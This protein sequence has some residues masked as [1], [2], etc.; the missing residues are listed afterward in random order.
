APTILQREHL[1]ASRQSVGRRSRLLVSASLGVT[2]L[3]VGL[4]VF[5]L[6]S[7]GRAIHQQVVTS[8]QA[9]AVESLND[10]S[11]DPE[12]SV[13]LALRAVE[14]EATPQTMLA[15]R[16]AL[17]AS[18]LLASLPN[19]SAALC[20]GQAPSVAF[21]PGHEAIAEYTCSDGV[22]IADAKT[23]RILR[24]LS[25]QTQAL[26]VL[27]YNPSGSLLAVGTFHGID[28]LSAESGTIENQLVMPGQAL[29]SQVPSSVTFNPSGKMIG[30]TAGA[31][32]SAL[33]DVPNGSLLELA[34]SYAINDTSL[35][36]T[37]DSQFAVAGTSLGVTPVFGTRTGNLVRT[38][39]TGGSLGLPSFVAASPIGSLLA[40]A[41]NTASG[42]G[43]VEIWNSRTWKEE[44]VLTSGPDDQFSGLAFSPDGTRV[45]LAED[46][47]SATVWSIEARS[48]IVALL[49]QTAVID[50][51]VF[52]P[53]GREVATASEDG[54]ARIWRA[55]GPD[56]NDLYLP[57]SIKSVALF[58]NHLV[59]ASLDDRAVQVS[60]W[61]LSGQE[62]GHFLIPGSSPDD[63]VSVSPDGH[64]VT[65]VANTPCPPGLPCP[66]VLVRVFSVRS[67]RPHR[68]YSVMGAESIA[69]SHNDRQIAVASSDLQVV[70]LAT[71]IV[72]SSGT[73]GGEQCGQ[74]GAPAFSMND[75]LVAWATRCGD[76][77]VFRL[78]GAQVAS[79]ST[80][81]QPSSVAFNPAGTQLAVSNWSGAVVVFNPLTGKREFSLPTAPSGV[82]SVAYSP[83]GR[84]IVTTLLDEQTEVW[85]STNPQ[86]LR[87]DQNAAPPLIAPAFDSA[88]GDFATGDAVGTVKI[89]AECPACGDPALLVRLARD[90]IVSQLTPLE[91]AAKQ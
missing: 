43:R 68:S 78:T 30:A 33:F 40:V 70:S 86:L 44:F 83:D 32:R 73:T 11:V 67:G 31:G 57:G 27:T 76:I 20:G 79:F 23:G 69:W 22:I 49:G 72:V 13:L 81:G 63:I 53:D 26:P 41:V 82:A 18:P 6:I 56:L 37:S 89:W 75:W 38:L 4:L 21:W 48:E 77:G 24:T 87:V 25:P 5:A 90:Q 34:G 35:T 1:L 59:V 16:E 66:P 42:S 17:D 47:G 10:L 54:T 14:E 64:F 36:F 46:N 51:I 91:Q 3:A 58:A 62:I 52:S 88:G 50:S 85:S 60:D 39:P 8:A 55:T 45:A 2:L 12:V 80:Q 74:D 71:G 7:R 61:R 9:F 29:S 65:D 19:V 28:L 84:Y 15:L